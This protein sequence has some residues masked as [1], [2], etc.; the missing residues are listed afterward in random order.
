[1]ADPDE[2]DYILQRIEVLTKYPDVRQRILQAVS[3][4]INEGE[5]S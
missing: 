3:Q 4:E 2:L 1:M 5:I